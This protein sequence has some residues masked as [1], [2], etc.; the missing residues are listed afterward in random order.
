MAPDLATG[1]VAAIT[2]SLMTA[3]KPGAKPASPAPVK[4]RPVEIA[5]RK[6]VMDGKNLAMKREVSGNVAP[7][8]TTSPAVNAPSPVSAPAGL[9]GAGSVASSSG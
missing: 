3:A 7:P 9:G 2:E 4:D 5:A 8:A 6:T 1:S